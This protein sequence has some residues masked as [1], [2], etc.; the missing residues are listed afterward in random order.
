MH[1]VVTAG[2]SYIIGLSVVLIF[3]E[4]VGHDKGHV[5]LALDGLEHG[6]LLAVGWELVVML[7]HLL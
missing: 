4:A 2:F 5:F 1:V 7:K 3:K 6:F